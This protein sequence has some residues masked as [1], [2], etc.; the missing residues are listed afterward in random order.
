MRVGDVERLEV[1]PVGLDLGPLGH[2]EAHADE[3]VFEA[4]AGLGDEVQVPEPS[5][6]RVFGEIDAF[7]FELY[8]AFGAADFLS[9]V[10][11]C[12]LR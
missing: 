12:I 5:S 1:V 3:H 6:W 9:G 10:G 4:V 7:R 8:N 2:G 11:Q